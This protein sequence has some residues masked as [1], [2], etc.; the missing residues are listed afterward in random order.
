MHSYILC[1]YP[2]LKCDLYICLFRVYI[3]T[4]YFLNIELIV[5]CFSESF[6]FIFTKVNFVCFLLWRLDVGNGLAG[7]KEKM[8]RKKYNFIFM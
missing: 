6:S 2:F 7:K 1:I 3:I 5:E 4:T 8:E